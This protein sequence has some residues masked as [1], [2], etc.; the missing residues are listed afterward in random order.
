MEVCVCVRARLYVCVLQA[1]IYELDIILTTYD[2]LSSEIKAKCPLLR[3]G[4]W[5]VVFD[6]PYSSGS[7]AR[8]SVSASANV[9]ASLSRRH[10]WAVTGEHTLQVHRPRRTCAQTTDGSAMPAH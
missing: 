7:K 3:Y 5:R 9:A 8:S 6:D 2:Q 1:P 10:A 4:Y